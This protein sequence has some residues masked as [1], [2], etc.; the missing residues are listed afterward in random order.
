MPWPSSRR[1][2]PAAARRPWYLT[3]WEQDDASVDWWERRGV[4]VLPDAPLETLTRL[5]R[6]LETGM[7]SSH[8]FRVRLA[9]DDLRGWP[10]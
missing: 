1:A 5:H 7:T 9:L 2:V 3:A 10:R 8:A 4:A 6:S